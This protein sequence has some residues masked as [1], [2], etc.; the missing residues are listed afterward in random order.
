MWL[1][2]EQAVRELG[3]LI[4]WEQTTDWSASVT[5]RDRAGRIVAQ[6]EALSTHPDEDLRASMARMR[7][8]REALSQYTRKQFGSS[9][10][11]EDE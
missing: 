3:L 8:L 10:L 2:L 4:E 11:E 1:T 6:A 7:A 5:L 9:I